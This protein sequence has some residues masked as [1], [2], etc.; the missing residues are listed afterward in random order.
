MTSSVEAPAGPRSLADRPDRGVGAYHAGSRHDYAAQPTTHAPPARTVERMDHTTDARRRTTWIVD[1]TVAAVVT[2][3]AVA[4]SIAVQNFDAARPLDVLAYALLV[5]GGASLV[6]RRRWPA[7]VLAATAVVAVAYDVSGFTGLIFPSLPLLVALY[8]A[9]GHGR[10]TLALTVAAALL[11]AFAAVKLVFPDG[12]A[13]VEAMLWVTGFV[14][15]A[16]VLGEVSRSRLDYTAAVEQRAR[17]AERTREEEA[18]RRAGEERLRIARELHDAVGH[19]LSLINV[20]ASVAAHLIDA[21]PDQ[22]REALIAIKDTSKGALRELR[23]TLGMLRQVDDEHAPRTPSPSLARLDELVVAMSAGGLDVRVE[24]T[25]TP[26]PLPPAV[27]RAAYRIVQESLTNVTRHADASTATVSL[28]YG[29]RDLTVQVDDNG[30]GSSG[31]VTTGGSGIA[32]MRERVAATGGDLEVTPLPEGGFC[33]R[34]RLPL[35]AER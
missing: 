27:D 32:G 4:G 14:T 9:T 31:T 1:L 17:E 28:D 16:L 11:V 7:A 10:R 8:T 22:A 5:G 2:A 3:L 35:G 24:R 29:P 12:P 23:D 30:R 34:A 25:G 18:R 15:S 6:A 26:R 21:Q 33:V 19:S 20:Q 13:D